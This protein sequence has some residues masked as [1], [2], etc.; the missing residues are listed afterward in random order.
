MKKP[1]VPAERGPETIVELLPDEVLQE[2]TGGAG[3]ISP[4]QL[5]RLLQGRIDPLQP[6]PP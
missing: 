5:D 3:T 1:R 6:P 4:Q 2:V